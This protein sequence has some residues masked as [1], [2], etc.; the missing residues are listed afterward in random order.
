M[1]FRRIRMGCGAALLTALIAGVEPAPA[2]VRNAINLSQGGA[3]MAI[4]GASPGAGMGE[5]VA[6]GDLNRDG[7]ADLI[8]GAPG[9]NASGRVRAGAVYVVYGRSGSPPSVVDFADAT[10]ST[11]EILGGEAGW[12]LGASVAVGDLNGDG[13]ADLIAGA[14]DASPGGRAGAGSVFVV[15]GRSGSLPQKMDLTATDDG[16]ARLDGEAA[17]DGF[18]RAVAAGNVNGDG[19]ADLIAGAP[20]ADPGGKTNAGQAYLYYGGATLTEPVRIA[21]GAAGDGLGSSAGVGDLNR[22]GLDEAVLGA[23]DATPVGGPAAGIVYALAGRPT[24]LPARLDLGASPAGLS[25]VMGDRPR[26]RAGSAITVGDVNGD[27]VGDLIV[28][29]RLADPPGGFNAGAV[30]VIYG[31]TGN[32]ISDVDLNGAPAGVTRILGERANDLTGQ[33]VAVGDLN[34]DGFGDVTLG[35]PGSFLTDDRESETPGKVFVVSGRAAMPP[36]IDLSAGPGMVSRIVGASAYLPNTGSSDRTGQSVAAG[37]LNGDGFADLIAG[38]PGADPAG[39]I[40]AGKVY[41]IVAGPRPDL[42]VASAGLTFGNVVVGQSKQLTVAV[43]N[44]GTATL[45]INTLTVNTPQFRVQPPGPYALNAGDSLLVAVTFAPSAAGPQSGT[46]TLTASNDP[47]KGFVSL[48]LSG[49]G[50][51]PDIDAPPSL[52]FGRVA[53]GAPAVSTL[54]IANLGASDL[55]VRKITASDSQFVAQP[56]SILIPAGAKLRVT[57]IFTPKVLGATS[58]TLRLLSDDP[59]EG[60]VT[61]ALTGSAASPRAATSASRLSFGSVLIGASFAVKLTVSNLGDA[62]LSVTRLASDSPQF[63]VFPTAFTVGPGKAQDVTVTF[64]PTASGPQAGALTLSAND[65]VNPTLTVAV[66]GDGGRQPAIALSATQF[67]FGA[68]DVGAWRDTSLYVY[69]R[70]DGILA[71]T[72]VTPSDTQFV[73]Q[74][75]SFTVAGKD[76]I[77]VTVRFSPKSG[78]DLSAAL[79]MTNNDPTSRSAIVTLSGRGVLRVASAVSA[80]SLDF[81]EVE[82]GA[83]KTLTLTVHSRGNA[84]LVVRAITSSDTQFVARPDS[85]TVAGGDSARIDISFSPAALRDVSA[86]LTIL[87]NDFSRGAIPVSLAGSG[88]RPLRLSLDLNPASG[89]QGATADT[90]QVKSCS[91]SLALYVANALNLSAFHITL[92]LPGQLLFKSFSDVGA[93][94]D[95][96]LRSA[97][98]GLTLSASQTGPNTVRVT[99]ALSNPTLATAPDGGGLLTVLQFD[100]F[101]PAEGF[102]R[103]DSALIS[104]EQAVFTRL[105]NAGPDTLRDA[106]TAKLIFS[107]LSGDGNA[108]GV[109]DTEDF[110]IL[111]AAFGATK[112]TPDYNPA[113][114]LNRDGVIDLTDFFMFSDRMGTRV[115]SCRKLMP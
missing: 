66:A 87:T 61:V 91:A 109:V 9:T 77:R 46:L 39:R 21:G 28:G 65:P 42:R 29:A 97:G 96:F 104:V 8:V 34:K 85:F 67:N 41:M 10:L 80:P 37:D 58:A 84:P 16:V 106:A 5:A 69:N 30:Y 53:L 14:P 71:V 36:V 114:D 54:Q 95:N 35:A 105:V 113:C 45:F 1:G 64:T 79:L 72:S 49:T 23:P 3:D 19:F 13:F 26:D 107:A 40:D 18:G 83:R 88:A 47:A 6:V 93:G 102:A 110:F 17:G 57:V 63:T 11:T 25:R 81:G 94:E 15:Y 38:A 48:S 2:Q 89:D 86:A 78:K 33:S 92:K 20:G 74:P 52:S 31:K 101:N 12:G 100:T 103:S 75:D 56:D 98:G 4:S 43:T 115:V 55:T 111:T 27:G 44:A 50:A 59:D 82:V 68:V 99:G 62:D 32:T 7:L 70:G 76:S 22:D 73:A 90:V 108:D 60:S 24:P 112:G 51:Q